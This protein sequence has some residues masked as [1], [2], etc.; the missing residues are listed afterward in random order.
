MIQSEVL[1]VT[2]RA[3][4]GKKATKKLRKEEKI[5]CNMYG[6]GSNIELYCNYSDVRKFIYTPS[7]H[8]VKLK[9]EEEEHET[10]IRE[11]Q[12]HPVTDRILHIDFLE[13]L[14]DKKVTV[15][16]P[17]KTVGRSKGEKEGGKVNMKLR[18]LK[19]KAYPKYLA[20]HFD[21]NIEHLGLGKSIKVAE[22][23][24]ENVEI[25]TLSTVAIVSVEVPRALK[26]AAKGEEA[27]EGEKETEAAT[28]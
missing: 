16:I 18:K 26:G 3:E 7:F 27:A 10:I 23:E 5:P 12:F 13:L 6:G 22:L 9:F 14:D 15:E 4:T 8:V 24:Y 20:T 25:L 11:V 28:V 17:L 21:V 2:K 1:E 19:I